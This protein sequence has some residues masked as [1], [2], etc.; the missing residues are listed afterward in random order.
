LNGVLCNTGQP[1]A[2]TI[3]VVIASDGTVGLHC[4]P[5]TLETLTTLVTNSGG[6]SGS[7]TSAPAGI[8]CSESAGT[9]SAQYGIDGSVVLTET[10]GSGSVFQGWTGDCSGSAATCTVTMDRARSV[11]ATFKPDTFFV[12]LAV[13]GAKCTTIGCSSYGGG[14]L[15]IGAVDCR[16]APQAPETLGV[17]STSFTAGTVVTV[18]AMTDQ[19]TMN[20]FSCPAG[21]TLSASLPTSQPVTCTFT[22]TSDVQVSGT[23]AA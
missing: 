18:T 15:T 14:S 4:N 8:N 12:R 2:G 11:T 22:L 5:T 19:G 13:I 23:W 20:G 7:V 1:T 10:P 16:V 9:C 21:G 6:S 17:C 3:S